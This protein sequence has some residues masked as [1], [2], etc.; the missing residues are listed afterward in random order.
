MFTSFEL[1][2]AESVFQVSLQGGKESGK[3]AARG[4]PRC[5]HG[6]WKMTRR[7]QLRRGFSRAGRDV[8]HLLLSGDKGVSEK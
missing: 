4:E 7:W 6:Q 1:R 3:G 5:S 2:A 8:T